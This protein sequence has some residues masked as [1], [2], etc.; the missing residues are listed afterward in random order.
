MINKKMIF[1]AA[2]FYAVTMTAGC[3]K[4]NKTNSPVIE[5]STISHIAESRGDD[6]IASESQNEIEKRI[7]D[8]FSRVLESQESRRSISDAIDIAFGQSSKN[9]HTSESSM[10]ENIDYSGKTPNLFK[11]S[12]KLDN[13]LYISI[14]DNDVDEGLDIK[15]KNK[16]KKSVEVSN[17][18]IFASD[19]FTLL[20]D[21][22]VDSQ[23]E[24]QVS[25]NYYYDESGIYFKRHDGNNMQS[26]LPETYPYKGE[27]LP[28]Y[29]LSVKI[30]VTIKNGAYTNYNK[31]AYITAITIKNVDGEPVVLKNEL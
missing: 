14:D 7:N 22:V 25:F 8:T 6:S 28:D 21:S 27:F 30:P 5:G 9:S 18:D 12:K 19:G 11:A 4:D 16:G 31:N 17:I 1:A 24:K 3:R 20:I 15:I 29:E 10:D 13:G 2:L 23:P 26:S